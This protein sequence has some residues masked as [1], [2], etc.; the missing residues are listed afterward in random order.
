MG[1]RDIE[2]MVKRLGGKV[3]RSSYAE[4]M[5]VDPAV[6]SK[7]LRTLS[8]QGVLKMEG[9]KRGSHYIINRVETEGMGG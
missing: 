7:A 8:K 3:T 4:A 9:S 1:K 2:R 6:A 5:G